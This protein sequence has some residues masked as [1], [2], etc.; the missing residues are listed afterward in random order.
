M[1]DTS[2]PPEDVKA[3]AEIDAALE[4]EAKALNDAQ[5]SIKA[6]MSDLTP[7]NR[8][9][10]LDFIPSFLHKTGERAY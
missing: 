10:L 2:N 4:A 6:I 8:R 5:E 1:V 7:N 9:L 3:Q